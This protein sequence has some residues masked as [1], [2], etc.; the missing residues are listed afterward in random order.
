MVKTAVSG[1]VKIKTPSKIK[2][3]L[4]KKKLLEKSTFTKKLEELQAKIVLSAANLEVMKVKLQAVSTIDPKQYALHSRL[5]NAAR[6]KHQALQK[7]ID[8]I[9]EQIKKINTWLIA[10]S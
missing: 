1:E 5:L 4:K 6:I 10:N 8:T 2:V 3:E 9:N 7:E